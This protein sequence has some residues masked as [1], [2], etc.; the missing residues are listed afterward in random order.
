MTL[1]IMYGYIATDMPT[2]EKRIIPMLQNR[3]AISRRCFRL[4]S[5][6]TNEMPARST[7]AQTA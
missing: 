1:G 4:T 3:G 6:R 5:S 7:N 2:N